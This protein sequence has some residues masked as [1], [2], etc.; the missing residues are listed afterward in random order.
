MRILLSKPDAL[1]DQLIA[2]GPV[3]ELLRRRPD[4]RLVWHVAATREAVAPLLGADVFAPDWR[5][6]PAAEEAARLAAHPSRLVLLP[7]PLDA[8]EPWTDDLRG[9]LRWWHDFLRATSWDACVLGLVNRTWVGDFTA[10]VAPAALRFGF[11]PLPMRQPLVNEARALAGADAPAFTRAE[12][13]A[14]GP[15]A[16]TP[17][18]VIPVA[19]RP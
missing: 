14:A 2:A 4:V 16:A 10:L 1:G 6:R 7:F 3:Q 19:A 9:R 5:N 13:A 17:G 12:I 8:H 15:G 11:D 18:P